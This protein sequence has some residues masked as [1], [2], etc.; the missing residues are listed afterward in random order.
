[1]LWEAGLAEAKAKALGCAAAG[2]TSA[3]S[4]AGWQAG[5][6]TAAVWGCSSGTTTPQPRPA[7]PKSLYSPLPAAATKS[8]SAS[9]SLSTACAC[10]WE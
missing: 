3:C 7:Q 6:P 1:M 8:M 4:L 5:A 9:R 2:V 10:S